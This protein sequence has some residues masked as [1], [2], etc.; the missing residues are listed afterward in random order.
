MG[1]EGRLSRV[2][3]PERQNHLGRHAGILRTP[4]T[5]GTRQLIDHRLIET[6]VLT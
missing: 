4:P 3:A 2:Q 5:G 6:S 1:R